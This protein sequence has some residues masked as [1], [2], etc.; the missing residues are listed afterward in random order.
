M[1]VAI[2][3]ARAHRLRRRLLT[4]VVA[5][6]LLG[7][8]AC[9]SDVAS[10]AEASGTCAGIDGPIKVGNVVTLSGPYAANGKPLADTV[11]A[12]IESFNKNDDICG[13]KI[14][15]V[16][17][18]DGG[19]PARAIAAGRQLVSDGVKIVLNAGAGQSEDALMPYL[20]KEKM[21]TISA[22]SKT[23][24][25][26]NVEAYPYHYSVY[27]SDK[28]T[29]TA[30]VNQ[31]KAQGW[32]NIAILGDGT[33]SPL[34]PSFEADLGAAGLTVTKSITY[35]PSAVDLTPVLAEARQ[36]GADVVAVEGITA[37]TALTQSL[38]T[39]GWQPYVISWG[40]FLAYAIPKADLP[41]GTFDGCTDYLSAEKAPNGVEGISPTTLDV[42]QS[43]ETTLGAGNPAVAYSEVGY[44]RLLVVKAAV[45]KAGSLDSNKLLAAMSDLTVQSAWPNS[46]LHFTA[47]RHSG[48]PDGQFSFCDLAV[49]PH[50]V[51]YQS[52]AVK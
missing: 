2:S 9:G 40:A 37:I 20:M 16:Q 42:L 39:M 33:P 26:D 51:R 34:G 11:S 6:A 13:Q 38:K 18:D 1:T 52:T 49:G 23:S 44:S 30:V 8:A 10:G 35:S 43:A 45:E 4:A 41:P 27:A 17:I 48:F 22:D 46:T 28:Q 50:G 19:D 32:D 14:E 36:S 21:L 25:L 5:G 12:A 3:P 7:T 31:I 29:G 24:L 47:E 15:N